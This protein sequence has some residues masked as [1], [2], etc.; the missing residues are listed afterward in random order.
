MKEKNLFES[1][2]QDTSL[3][4]IFNSRTRIFQQ[5]GQA[6]ALNE[7]LWRGET[8]V[9]GNIGKIANAHVFFFR[10]GLTLHKKTDKQGNFVADGLASGTYELLI[11]HP[12]YQLLWQTVEVNSAKNAWQFKLEKETDEKVQEWLRRALASNFD[13]KLKQEDTT[14]WEFTLGFVDENVPR[15]PVDFFFQPY[16]FMERGKSLSWQKGD[17]KPSLKT[18]SLREDDFIPY[19]YVDQH[20]A[21]D[22]INQVY[23]QVVD[24][25]T[26][27]PV[28]GAAVVIQGTIKGVLTDAYGRFRLT[29]LPSQSVLVVNYVGYRSKEIALNSST[30]IYV[31]LQADF[32]TY[33]W[34][35]N[36]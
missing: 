33:G 4:K 35:E 3:N 29:N 13:L 9:K 22:S 18:I 6:Y 31:E 10:K 27:D 5:N 21:I 7:Q 16:T 20:F 1:F 26:G 15:S 24:K 34:G 14:T 12:D 8:M 25:E 30:W 28:E 17:P 11:L 32:F 36:A 2:E 19:D 23:G